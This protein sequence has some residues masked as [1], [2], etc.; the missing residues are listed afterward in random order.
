MG[1][2]SSRIFFVGGGVEDTLGTAKH[3][4]SLGEFFKT[5]PAGQ[6]P[7]PMEVCR[8][9]IVIAAEEPEEAAR[10][11]AHILLNPSLM[12]L[13]STTEQ[14]ATRWLLWLTHTGCKLSHRALGALANLRKKTEWHADFVDDSTGNLQVVSNNIEE[15]DDAVMSY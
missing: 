13:G 4:G 9:P 12:G 5:L 14:S 11:A 6:W 10:E 3:Q 1:L 8:Q 15:R 7:Q 2:I